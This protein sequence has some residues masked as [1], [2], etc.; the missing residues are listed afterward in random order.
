MSRGEKLFEMPTLR[1]S[2]EFVLPTDEEAEGRIFSLYEQ[3]DPWQRDEGF[4]WYFRAYDHCVNLARQFPDLDLTYDQIAGIVAALSPQTSWEQN[5]HYARML[6][7]EDRA[8]TLTHAVDSALKIKAGE[9]PITVLH[10]RKKNNLKVRTFHS[11]IS[12]PEVSQ[13][14]TIDRHAW[15]LIFNDPKA[16]K[17][18]RLY[19]QPPST[20]GQQTGTGR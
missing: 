9:D 6:L 8:P 1:G 11:N 13:D 17:K 20:D 5:L 7:T 3:L 16:I 15:N 14:V 18:S 4:I 19:I 2:G 10:H 12:D